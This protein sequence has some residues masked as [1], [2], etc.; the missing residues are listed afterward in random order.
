MWWEVQPLV[1]QPKS[2]LSDTVYIDSSSS[3]CLISME[4]KASVIGGGACPKTAYASEIRSYIINLVKHNIKDNS[5]LIFISSANDVNFKSDPVSD[6]LCKMPLSRLNNYC[7]VKNMVNILRLHESVPKLSGTH[8][9][10]SN[11]K[12]RTI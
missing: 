8:L 11:T 5:L 1:Q 3:E 6:I 4:S 2:V 9:P 10:T 7:T 12:K